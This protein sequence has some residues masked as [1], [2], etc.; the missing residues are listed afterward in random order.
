[1]ALMHC[2]KGRILFLGSALLAVVVMSHHRA[3]AADETPKAVSKSIAQFTSEG[4]VKTPG[5]LTVY[6][7]RAD[8]TWYLQIPEAPTDMI[9]VASILS[10]VGANDLEL[11]GAS[12]D[13]GTTGPSRLVSFRRVGN[14]VLLV[15]RNG[16][17]MSRTLAESVPSTLN[18]A[19]ADAVLWGFDI[20]AFG[21]G[22]ILIDATQFLNRDPLGVAR[23]LKAAK[24]GDYEYDSK[25]SGIEEGGLHNS[26]DSTDIDIISTFGTEKAIENPFLSGVV[27]DEHAITIRERHSFVRLPSSGYAPRQYDP[28]S[29]FFETTYRDISAKPHEPLEQR[30]IWRH[31]LQKVQPGPAP[32]DAQKPIVY[33]VDPSVPVEY[34]SAVIEGASWW[35]EAFE[36]AGYKNALQVKML[37]ETSGVD[38]LAIGVNIITWTPRSSRGWSY[39]TVITDPRTGEILKATV[40]LDGMRLRYDR[41]LLE[42]LTL[43]FEGQSSREAEID[44]V[45]MQRLRNLVAHEVGHTLGLRHQFVGSA[46]FDTSVMDYPF[47]KLDLDGPAGIKIAGAYGTSLRS[48]M[49]MAPTLMAQMMPM[50]LI[51]F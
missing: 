4:F 8:D 28:R 37:T 31:R 34:R 11:D 45:L 42:G 12:L 38:P 3:G 24:L 14:R 10:G 46:Q 26:S 5:L 23:A 9:Y 50:R 17:Y 20:K 33:Y 49:A 30:L 48:N 27:A 19:F 29:G 21:S 1:M 16:N 7:K 40:R 25:R 2:A 51:H 22:Q 15:E 18:G 44:V 35:N 41:K 32:S 13:R 43:P 47:P 6:R 36:A 39:G